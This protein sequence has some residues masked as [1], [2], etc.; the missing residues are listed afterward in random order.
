SGVEEGDAELE[1]AV[2]CGQAL[3]FG[4]GRAPLRAA[5]RPGPKPQSGFGA[6]ET[7][8]GPDISPGPRAHLNRS[9]R[10]GRWAPAPPSRRS[11]DDDSWAR[12][13]ASRRSAYNLLHKDR[14]RKDGRSENP[15]G[16]R[17]TR[18]PVT[19]NA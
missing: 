9:L 15:T 7:Q 19:L 14:I 1:R 16:C 6:Q 4:R 11:R 2:D 10:S 5:H 18:Q 17:H 13:P 8:R 3:W 12:A